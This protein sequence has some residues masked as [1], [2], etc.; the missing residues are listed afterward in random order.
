[1]ATQSFIALIDAHSKKQL[2]LIKA[3]V[4]LAI[5]GEVVIADIYKETDTDITMLAVRNKVPVSQL[6]D[7]MKA[8]D[9]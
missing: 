6:E 8:V 5:D 4:T 3:N 9:G 7:V 2:K 1:M